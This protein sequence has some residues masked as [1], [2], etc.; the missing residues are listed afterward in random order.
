M[1]RSRV[2]GDDSRVTVNVSVALHKSLPL[3]GQP[4]RRVST[5]RCLAADCDTLSGNCSSSSSRLE[6]CHVRDS[7]TRVPR[8]SLRGSPHAVPPDLSE[9]EKAT[10]W[11]SLRRTTRT[12]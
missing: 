3:S 5:G 11:G 9:G 1:V 8:E 6:G 12:A 10:D 2:V 4:K 7:K